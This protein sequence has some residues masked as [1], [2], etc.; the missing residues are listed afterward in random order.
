M[1]PWAAGEAPE[2]VDGTVPPA[3]S[4]GTAH[5]NAYLSW[6]ENTWHWTVAVLMAATIFFLFWLW[7]LVKYSTSVST[8][9]KGRGKILWRPSRLP[10]SNVR[11][12][13]PKTSK[14]SHVPS[15]P[16]MQVVL[17]HRPSLALLPRPKVPSRPPPPKIPYQ[18]ITG[19]EN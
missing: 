19:A 9:M 7:E 17:Y 15:Q 2:T 12:S 10:R 1:V 14:R 4:V 11:Y 5:E 3:S 16:R 18:W 6:G 13:T 8:W